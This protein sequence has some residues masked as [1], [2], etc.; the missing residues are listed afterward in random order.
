[1]RKKTIITNQRTAVSYKDRQNLLVHRPARITMHYSPSE[2][3]NLISAANNFKERTNMPSD[4]KQSRN[5]MRKH[6]NYRFKEFKRF[7]ESKS[8]PFKAFNLRNVY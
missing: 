6:E 2:V 7:S 3:G 4:F 8:K 5:Q 1:M